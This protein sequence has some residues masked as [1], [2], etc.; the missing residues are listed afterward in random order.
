MTTYTIQSVVLPSGTLTVKLHSEY[1]G[2]TVPGTATLIL[3][4]DLVERVSLY[5]DGTIE[6]ENMEFG[7]V[8][9]Y[10]TYAEG[11]WYKVLNGSA[12]IQVLI[13]EGA[14]DTHFFWGKVIEQEG[15]ISEASLVSGNYLRLGRFTCVSLLSKL[16]D[17]TIDTLETECDSHDILRGEVGGGDHSLISVHDLICSIATVAYNPGSFATTYFEVKGAS[18]EFWNTDRGWTSDLAALYVDM[19]LLSGTS[20]TT[21]AGPS[22]YQ[23]WKGR[24]A[25]CYELLGAIARSL[26]C[27]ARHYYDVSDAEH[28]IHFVAVANAYN[29]RAYV[30]PS[31]PVRST[32]S[33]LTDMVATG[34]IVRRSMGTAAA[35]KSFFQGER[36]Y[37]EVEPDVNMATQFDISLEFDSD[38]GWTDDYLG[39]DP[40]W[41]PLY[42][43]EDNVTDQDEI[44]PAQEAQYM[45]IRTKRYN[46]TD[47]GA[48]H[49]AH[50]SFW[51]L[52]LC[53]LAVKRRE[54]EREYRG[55]AVSDGVTTTHDNAII[56]RYTLIDDRGVTEVLEDCEDA[57]TGGTV[58]MTTTLDT[59]DF[60]IGSGAMKTEVAAGAAAGD[61]IAYEP[62]AGG[63]GT[64]L[65]AYGGI[66]VYIKSSVNTSW[67]DL[68]L[69]LNDSNVFSG[70][71]RQVMSLPALTADTWTRVFLR[72]SDRDL[73]TSLAYVALQMNVDLGAFTVRLDDVRATTERAFRAVEVKKN[74]QDDK[75]FVRWVED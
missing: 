50:A 26:G 61:V 63:S 20:V 52:I 32:Y 21:P 34:G 6:A 49:G 60:V 74:L 11:F 13:D 30:V 45:D 28:R 33:P 48:F 3:D 58:N 56:N 15:T 38:D 37:Y 16:K 73:L 69:L 54:Y 68:R 1:A 36:A 22:E 35:D 40:N 51:H 31:S 29:D 39:Y 46:G 65:T 41:D 47:I 12:E 43:V 14:G 8:E 64:D 53:P 18:F 4:G 55:I 71:V 42:M 27:Y 10:T 2:L 44:H 70:T 75:L 59:G 62:T 67:D 24:F 57:W 72:F 9:D 23:S 5:S 7:Y 19:G 66:R 25:S 17:V